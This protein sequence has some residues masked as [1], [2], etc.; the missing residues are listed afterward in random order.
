M[1][2]KIRTYA[3]EP[4]CVTATRF[5]CGSMVLYDHMFVVF[6]ARRAQKTTNEKRGSTALPKAQRANCVSRKDNN[7]TSER[8]R[9]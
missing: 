2:H 8:P 4:F 9:R 3:V 6:C 1:A 7:T 5:A